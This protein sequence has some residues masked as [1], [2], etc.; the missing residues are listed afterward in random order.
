MPESPQKLVEKK[1]KKANFQIKEFC[2]DTSET[3]ARVFLK[4]GH[5]QKDAQPLV[6]PPRAASSRAARRSFFS[7]Q[8]V[9][10]SSENS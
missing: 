5:D 8:R 6:G 4:L 7:I 10:G 9:S 1:K 2:L 3:K